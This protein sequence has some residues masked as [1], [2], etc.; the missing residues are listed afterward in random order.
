LAEFRRAIGLMSGTSLDGVDVALI[1]TDGERI[2][3]FGPAR[4][5]AY[6]EPDRTLLREARRMPSA[7]L[8]VMRGPASWGGPRRW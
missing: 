4:T 6:T 3:A 5:Y 2:A 7:F 8:I 1:T